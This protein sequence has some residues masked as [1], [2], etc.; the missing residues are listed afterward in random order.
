VILIGA[1]GNRS[2]YAR[3]RRGN[4]Y[5]VVTVSEPFELQA[6]QA[7]DE[8]NRA[9]HS[10]APSGFVQEPFLV[11]PENVDAEGG[12]HDMFLPGNDYKNR[13]LRLWGVAGN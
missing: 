4:E 8:C 11:T 1:D 5:Q 6:Y 13:Y 10:E 9:F 3:I 2:A 7:I 12:E